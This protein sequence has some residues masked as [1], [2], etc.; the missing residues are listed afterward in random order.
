MVNR[1][2]SWGGVETITWY[3]LLFVHGGDGGVCV[4]VDFCGEERVKG[5]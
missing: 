3:M 1:C 2:G 4:Y 5:Y